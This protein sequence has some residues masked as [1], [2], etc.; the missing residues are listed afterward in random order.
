MNTCRRM[1]GSKKDPEAEAGRDLCVAGRLKA[2]G[3]GKSL[4]SL[5][6]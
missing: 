4:E 1:E 6:P 5:T 3:G 2:G